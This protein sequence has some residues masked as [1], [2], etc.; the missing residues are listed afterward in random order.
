MKFFLYLGVFLFLP[1]SFVHAH[2]PN[3][4]EQ[5]S[6]HDITTIVEPTL[7]QAFYGT[8]RGFPH[9]FEIRSDESF[10]LHVEVLVP[11]SDTS[12]ENVSGIIIRETGRQGRVTEVARM[13][14]KDASWESFYE[15]WGGDSYRRGSVS[16][17]EVESGI[18]RIEVST[19]D[20]NA[21]YVLVVGSKEEF[22]S[23]GYFETVKRIA[24]VKTFFGKS[25]F[26]VIE[27]PFVYVP[28]LFSMFVVFMAWLRRRRR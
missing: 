8:L 18:Y 12:T 2:V 9:T 25:K 19:P 22:G 23:I 26:M 17:R 10:T 24:D 28:L 20:N 27:S 1:F 21:P 7:S 14:A 15:P 6:L 4:V 16:E 11:D 13:L 3:L 5:N